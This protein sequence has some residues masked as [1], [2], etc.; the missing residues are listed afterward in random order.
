MFRSQRSVPRDDRLFA[1]APV[2]AVDQGGHD[3]LNEEL[4]TAKE[5]GRGER[6]RIE[7]FGAIDP[8]ILGEAILGLPGEVWNPAAL[9]L[10]AATKEPA[11]DRGA[12][13]RATEEIALCK[14]DITNAIQIGFSVD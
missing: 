1:N 14:E 3:G 2:E 7:K 9:I 12:R 10:D 13:K 8:V 5:T 11:L 4:V 6:R